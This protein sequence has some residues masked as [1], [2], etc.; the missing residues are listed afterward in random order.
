MDITSLIP[1]EPKLSPPLDPGFVPAALVNRAFRENATESGGGIPVR[2]ALER[3]DGAIS[4]YDF[5]IL[6]PDS[7]LAESN[8]FIVERIVKFLLWQRGGWKVWIGGPP[9]IGNHIRS[10]YSVTR[11]ASPSFDAEFMA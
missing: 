7:P 10:A 3:N 8:P 1:V 6:P 2:I 5:R 4:T 11:I 9:E